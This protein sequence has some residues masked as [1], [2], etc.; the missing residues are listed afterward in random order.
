MTGEPEFLHALEG[1]VEADLEL[2]AAGTPPAGEPWDGSIE[3]HDNTAA[4]QACCFG[5]ATCQWLLPADCATAGGSTQAIDEDCT[6]CP[7]A[8]TQ[9]CCYP[10]NTCVEVPPD[11]C[12]AVFGIPQGAGT[13]CTPNPCNE[14]LVACCFPDGSCVDLT[15]AG[16]AS[17]FGDP[18]GSG[19]DCNPNPCAPAQA[20]CFADGS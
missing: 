1:E 14:E 11:Q 19:S 7:P 13:D 17:I 15:A 9:A 3:V 16:C 8:T 12:T 20:C 5:D 6:T 4:V 2:Q 10:D 18:Q